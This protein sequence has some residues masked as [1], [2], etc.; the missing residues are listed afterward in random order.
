MAGE[1]D[2]LLEKVPVADGRFRRRMMAGGIVVLVS[3]LTYRSDM[4]FIGASIGWGDILSAPSLLLVFLVIVYALGGV[5]EI[6]GQIFV[7]RAVG[8]AIHFFRS[9]FKKKENESWGI[10]AVIWA[11][12]AIPAFY[13]VYLAFLKGLLGNT[14]YK[15]T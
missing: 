4:T 5:I 6:L 2:K 15:M 13:I 3:V 10:T 14:G 7:I 11:V 9:Q 12:K 8:E 1:V